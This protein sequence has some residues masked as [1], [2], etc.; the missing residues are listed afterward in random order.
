MQLFSDVD[1]A[2]AMPWLQYTVDDLC[3]DVLEDLLR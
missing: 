3:A 2:D 1:I